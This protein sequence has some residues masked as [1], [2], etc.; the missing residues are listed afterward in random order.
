[1]G[2]IQVDGVLISIGE[3][4]KCPKCQEFKNTKDFLTLIK[5]GIFKSSEIICNICF[6]KKERNE[7]KGEL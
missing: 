2:S 5:S 6:K 4:F 1:M 3:I 7:K